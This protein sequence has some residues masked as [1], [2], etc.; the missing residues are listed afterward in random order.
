MSAPNH[1]AFVPYATDIGT[2]YARETAL[3]RTLE[4]FN[5]IRDRA[6]D[7]LDD[8]PER[9]VRKPLSLAAFMTS[10]PLA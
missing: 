10:R 6:L 7:L 3:A 2:G 4:K 8:A 5:D 9:T 1:S